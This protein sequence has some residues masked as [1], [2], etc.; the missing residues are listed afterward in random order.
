MRL[1]GQGSRQRSGS[2]DHEADDSIEVEIEEV[3]DD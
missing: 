1:R 2:F 3:A